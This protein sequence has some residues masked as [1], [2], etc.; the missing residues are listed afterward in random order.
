MKKT[1]K[2]RILG[3]R[4]RGLL[5]IEIAKTLSCSKATVSYHIN[6]RVRRNVSRRQR[7]WKRKN[8][9]A[10]KLH[11]FK[12]QNSSKRRKFGIIRPNEGLTL[13]SLMQKIGANQKCYL[14]GVPIDLDDRDAYCLN[15]IIPIARGGKINLTNCG[16]AS[17]EATAAKG[18]R[19][20][21]EFI[22]LCRMVTCLGNRKWHRRSG[23][24]G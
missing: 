24:A 1:L 22:R 23:R 16:L 3:L 12:Y 4:A 2:D 15:H 9:L 7:K 14:T 8:V 13:K 5:N 21:S 11:N 17:A 19:T 20:V 6:P 18:A 10:V